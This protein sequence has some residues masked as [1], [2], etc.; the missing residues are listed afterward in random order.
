VPHI[1]SG[2]WLMW[3]RRW[4]KGEATMRAVRGGVSRG[5]DARAVLLPATP[6][7]SP[8]GSAYTLARCGGV[9]VV[10]DREQLV[11]HRLEH[12]EHVEPLA[13]GTRRIPGAEE[14]PRDAPL[15]RRP[16]PVP[17]TCRAWY[18]SPG[19]CLAWSWTCRTARHRWPARS[20]HGHPPCVPGEG[21][22]VRG[23]RGPVE[24]GGD[25]LPVAQR[26]PARDA[27]VDMLV[28]AGPASASRARST[29]GPRA[30]AG[31]ARGCRPGTPGA[32]DRSPTGYRTPG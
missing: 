28:P 25:R 7:G 22:T 11:H 19:W 17:P 20:R 32:S 3:V 31:H 6:E 16:A 8:R 9:G 15:V 26:G 2:D 21:A 14:D 30:A 27:H 24:V 5:R 4:T 13:A 23:A 1:L 18:P 29:S 10:G 12:P